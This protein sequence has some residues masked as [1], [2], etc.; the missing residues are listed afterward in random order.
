MDPDGGEA[1]VA[2]VD[3]GSASTEKTSDSSALPKTEVDGREERYVEFI[4][5][6]EE[7]EA[8]FYCEGTVVLEYI[9]LSQAFLRVDGA[10]RSGTS[11]AAQLSI[12]EFVTGCPD[13]EAQ[14]VNVTVPVSSPVARVEH[15]EGFGAISNENLPSG[16]QTLKETRRRDT[17]STGIHC[18]ALFGRSLLTIQLLISNVTSPPPLTS[19]KIPVPGKMLEPAMWQMSA[20]TWRGPSRQ[21]LGGIRVKAIKRANLH[22]RDDTTISGE[23]PSCYHEE[24]KHLVRLLKNLPDTIPLGDAH[25]FLD[26][27]P[28]PVKVARAGCT[29]SVVSHSLEIS[30]GAH[31]APGPTGGDITIIFKSRGPALE[32]VATVLRN[33]I[34]GNEG[35]NVLL[36]RWVDDLT[37]AA[38][39]AIEASGGRIH[40]LCSSALAGLDHRCFSDTSRNSDYSRKAPTWW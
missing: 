9:L 32:E 26:Y 25:N 2:A 10:R 40:F 24:L 39:A 23:G 14:T 4:L 38:F 13:S 1:V 30:F 11:G 28:N 6:L 7:E 16:R 36:V 22:L 3:G 8:P 20:R 33:H 12:V 31:K 5:T 19:D 34:T 35:P 15:G 29:N 21:S 37:K 17:A 18:P 27:T